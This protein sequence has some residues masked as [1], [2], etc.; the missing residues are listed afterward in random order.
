M[1]ETE[2]PK[3]QTKTWSTRRF[4]GPS[5]LNVDLQKQKMR[6]ITTN[7]IR[8]WGYVQEFK[9]H[10]MSDLLI[11]DQLLWADVVRPWEV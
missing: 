2:T 1:C 3:K 11:Y 10:F 7:N 6:Q 5:S 9:S 8:P 4:G